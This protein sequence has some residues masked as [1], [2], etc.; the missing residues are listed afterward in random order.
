MPVKQRV[1]SDAI[2]KKDTRKRRARGKSRS[3]RVDLDEILPEYDFSGA[4]RNRYAA[5]VAQ[6][7]TL[8]ELDPNVAAAFPTAESVNSALRALAGII[9]RHPTS[10]S[11]Q[12][13]RASKP[14][15][16]SR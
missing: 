4:K 15:A 9:Q 7:S 12:Q 16:A 8:V 3:P 11:R 5:G 14:H 10:P 6:R 1:T 13:S 2:M